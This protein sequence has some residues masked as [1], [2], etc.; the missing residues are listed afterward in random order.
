V[1]NLEQQLKVYYGEKSLPEENVSR[2]LARAEHLRPSIFIRP[3]FSLAIATAAVVL[4]GTVLFW[5]VM[6]QRPTVTDRIIAEIATIHQHVVGVEVASDR[7]DILQAKL[8]QLTFSIIPTQPYLLEQFELLGGRYSS[9]QGNMA[10][11][12]T[13]RERRSGI[14]CTL[15]VTSLTS[16]L[17]SIVPGSTNHDGIMVKIWEDQ[18]RL[19]GLAGEMSIPESTIDG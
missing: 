1:D 19:F 3:A 8:P 4:I 11:Q 14:L 10:A 13:V 18:G 5:T 15:Y 2:M 9:I 16:D 6:L 12:L 7:Y 17:Q